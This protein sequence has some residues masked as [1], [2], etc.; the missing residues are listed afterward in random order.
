MNFNLKAPCGNCP[1]KKE[2]AIELMRGRLDGIIKELHNDY[3]TFECHKTVHGPKGGTWTDEDRYKPSGNE[4]ACVGAIAYMLKLNRT[5]ILTRLGVMDGKVDL[6]AMR[7][8]GPQIIDPP[9][10]AV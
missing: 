5:S 10:G 9:T 1:F 7:A 8:L 3:R 2:G 4:S 6:R